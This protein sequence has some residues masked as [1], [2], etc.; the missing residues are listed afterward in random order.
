MRFCHYLRDS[1]TFVRFLRYFSGSITTIS[2]IPCDNFR[3]SV[4]ISVSWWFV[5][6]SF[7]TFS[8]SFSIYKYRNITTVHP[9]LI[10]TPPPPICM[11][12][13]IFCPLYQNRH[14]FVFYLFILCNYFSH[15]GCQSVSFFSA[16]NPYST[17]TKIQNP[18]PDHVL[19]RLFPVQPNKNYTENKLS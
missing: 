19:H 9:F 14:C 17:F 16:P 1:T 2:D 4:S 11:L 15:R 12:L 18:D 3:G 13:L 10:L 7:L 6:H 8:T 5:C